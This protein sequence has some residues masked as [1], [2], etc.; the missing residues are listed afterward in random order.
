MSMV[1]NT[2]TINMYTC[3]NNIIRHNEQNNLDIHI[4]DKTYLI[5][6]I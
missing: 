5:Q 3:T 4:L 1:Y 6:T 2:F